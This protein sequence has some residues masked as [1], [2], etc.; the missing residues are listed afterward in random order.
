MPLGYYVSYSNKTR[1]TIF[2]EREYVSDDAVHGSGAITDRYIDV[3]LKD[4][5]R[6]AKNKIIKEDTL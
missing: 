5:H 1:Q 6:S 4:R 2:E 3:N